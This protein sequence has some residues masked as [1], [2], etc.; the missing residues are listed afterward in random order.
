MVERKI[1][2]PEDVW[3]A[4][5]LLAEILDVPVAEIG[6]IG[7]S[8]YVAFLMGRLSKE[9]HPAAESLWGL[10]DETKQAWLDAGERAAKNWPL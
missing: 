10:F 7:F 2:Y 4:G 3:R 6:R 5:E 8:S 9:G 1:R